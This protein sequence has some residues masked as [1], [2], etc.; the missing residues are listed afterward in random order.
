MISIP[1]IILKDTGPLY[2]KNMLYI[3]QELYDRKKIKKG[4]LIWNI[5]IKKTLK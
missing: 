4:D 1:C 2:R 5:I 3:I